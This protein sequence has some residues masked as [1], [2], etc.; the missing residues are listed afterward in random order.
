MRTLRIYL[1]SV[2][3]F[4]PNLIVANET[5]TTKN[6]FKLGLV[7]WTTTWIITIAA[8]CYIILM[9][10]FCLLPLLKYALR[11]WSR[12]GDL[13][14]SQILNLM[15]FYLMND[16]L[17]WRFDVFVYGFWVEIISA[18]CVLVLG[19]CT[20]LHFSSGRRFRNALT[21]ILRSKRCLKQKKLEMG[22]NYPA[23]PYA[24]E[25]KEFEWRNEW[26]WLF[27]LRMRQSNARKMRTR[28]MVRRYRES[29]CSRDESEEWRWWEERE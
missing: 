6:G 11:I 24:H 20:G 1:N 5:T 8:P 29:Y 21:E 27:S 4:A 9:Y 25:T 26:K 18:P 10:D 2:F 22:E 14:T 19:V 23:F 15:F 3:L 13:I 28:E 17:C 7:F 16:C 12:F